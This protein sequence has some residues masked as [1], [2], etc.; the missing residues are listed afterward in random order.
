MEAINI[1]IKYLHSTFST[2]VTKLL[3]SSLLASSLYLPA[4]SRLTLLRLNIDPVANTAVTATSLESAGMRDV[5]L[6]ALL[7]E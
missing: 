4:W 7:Q 1:I 2:T 5:E 3:P 6:L